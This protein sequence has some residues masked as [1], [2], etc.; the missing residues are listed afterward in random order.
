MKT[1]KTKK[2][3]K[4]EPE[5]EYIRIRI[6]GEY[7]D[8]MELPDGVAVLV[9]ADSE[10][11]KAVVQT[12]SVIEDGK[13]LH[14]SSDC[15]ADMKAAIER[16]NKRKFKEKTPEQ[17]AEE[18]ARSKFRKEWMPFDPAVVQDLVEKMAQANKV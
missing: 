3:K 17:L 15:P 1:K 11:G 14:Y 6:I 10:D 5:A 18:E 7:G 12:F 13:M 8:K 9:M 4:S 2:K 16:L